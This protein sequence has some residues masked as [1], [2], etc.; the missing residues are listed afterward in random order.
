[1][2]NIF[3]RQHS[4]KKTIVWGA[5]IFSIFISLIF[6]LLNFLFVYAVE[7]QFFEQLL[8]EETQY[9]Q[10][11]WQ[12]KARAIEPQNSFMQLYDGVENFPQDLSSAYKQHPLQSEYSGDEGRHY[13]LSYIDSSDKI[14]V[15]EVSHYLVVRPIRAN[16]L[17]VLVLLS[18]LMISLAL[19]ISYLMAKRATMPLTELADLLINTSPEN[20]PTNFS[21][22]FPNNEIGL[23]ANKLE[24]VMLRIKNFIHREQHF[25]RDTSHELRTPV[26][27]IKNAIELLEQ[28]KPNVEEKVFI[29]RIALANNQMEQTITTLLSL[30]RENENT[31]S[32]NE[33][34]LLPS[35]ERTIID[36]SIFL[37]NKD[38]ELELNVS[39]EA[40]V[41]CS[42]TVLQILLN[43]LLSNAFQ[44]T[45]HGYI[46]IS[47]E[48]KVLSVG[49]T[50]GGIDEEIKG[51]VMDTLVRSK[52]SQGFGIGLSLVK[53]LCETYQ[54]TLSLSSTN[55]GVTVSIYFP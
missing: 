51:N 1:M 21:Q 15:A 44:Y 32:T 42:S 52:Q 23:L 41:Q 26:T 28:K 24:E 54:L 2:I 49:D 39:P 47:F 25:T 14:L 27:I 45:D 53:R 9:I 37:K 8:Q 4:L 38:I 17:T 5:C 19:L 13:H 29:E 31:A 12:K 6:S 50:S 10:D 3:S 35:I 34:L 16:I 33:V 55:K 43:N 22:N 36:Q 46:Y 7:D 40:N 18:I 20:L 30:A 11:N 48:N